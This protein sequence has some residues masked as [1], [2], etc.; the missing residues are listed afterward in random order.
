LNLRYTGATRTQALAMIR[1]LADVAAEAAAVSEDDRV[2]AAGG[3]VLRDRAA[4][5]EVVAG[6]WRRR[7]SAG[8]WRLSGA[9]LG[10]HR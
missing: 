10:G 1:R 5:G 4:S 8:K 7:L 6:G 3:S 2:R 9:G